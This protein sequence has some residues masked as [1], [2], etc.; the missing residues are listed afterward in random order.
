MKNSKRA[1]KIFITILF[2]WLFGHLIYIV[3]DGLTDKNMHADIAVVLGNTVHEDGTLS[4]RLEKRM[5][6]GLNL[7]RY[8]R[9]KKILVSGGL[10]KEGFY[11]GDK[12]KEY[13]IKN[14]VPDSIIIVDNFGNNTLATVN[15]TL[16]LK[17]SLNFKSLIVVSQ[18][19][20]LTRTKML[21]R[22]QHFK[23]VSSTSPQYFEFRDIY[24]LL[25]E[26]VAY[27]TG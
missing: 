17:D 8:G 25:R 10:G 22:K 3:I 12:M 26:F 1:F 5:E 15:N 20:H 27:Y 4:E 18:Y 21:F 23:N 7:Y 14:K 2:L 9:V 16:K 19:F 24:S 13:L 6:C 11:E